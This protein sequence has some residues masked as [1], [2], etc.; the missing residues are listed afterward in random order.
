MPWE[1]TVKSIQRGAEGS[2]VSVVAT[3]GTQEIARELRNVL[4]YGSLIDQ[5]RAWISQL[6]DQDGLPPVGEKL[7][8]SI[9]PAP[10]PTEKEVFAKDAAVLR[11]M[12]RAIELGFKKETDQDFIDLNESVSLRLKENPAWV[13]FF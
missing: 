12:K 5:V 4:S 2:S 3:D 7:D 9:V 1:A 11:S 8:L 10:E 6:E 13:E